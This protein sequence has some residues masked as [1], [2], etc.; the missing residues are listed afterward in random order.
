MSWFKRKPRKKYIFR[1]AHDITTLELAACFL[2]LLMDRDGGPVA[3][4]M[5]GFDENV[6]RHWV[7]KEI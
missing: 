3:E 5:A 2:M 6:M 4:T 7:V 1:P